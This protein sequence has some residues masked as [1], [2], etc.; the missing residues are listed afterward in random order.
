MAVPDL[1]GDGY[2]EETIR[3]EYEWKPPRCSTCLIFG[4]SLV[5]CPK[6]AF[7]RV[8]N[9]LEKGKGKSSGADD[10]G[11][12]EVKKSSGINEGTSNSPK[13]VPSAGKKNV[14]TLG[15]FSLCNSFKALNVDPVIEEVETGNKAS[16]SG[17]QEEGN[18]TIIERINVFEKHLLKEK[19]VLVDDDGKPLE[20]VDYS[21][22][23]GSEDEV[24]SINNEMARYLASKPFGVGYVE[25]DEVVK[26]IFNNGKKKGLGMRILEWMLTKE[27]KETKHYK[28]YAKE[29][30]LDVPMTHSQPIESTQGMHRTPSAPRPLTLKNNKDFEDQQAVKKVEEHLIDM[31]IEKIM[32][33][34][35]KS[36]ANKFV[37]DIMNKIEEESV[38]AAL[39]RKKGKGIV[40]IK[41]TPLTTPIRSPRTHTDSLSSYKEE[42]KELTTSKTTS[43]SSKPKTDRSKHIQ[44]AIARMSKRYGYI[45]RHMKKSFMPRKD[46]DAIGKI[47]EETLKKQERTRATFSS[48]VSNDVATKIPPQFDAFLMNYMNNHI[49]HVHPTESASSF[50]PDL[51]QQLYLKMKDDG[52]ACNADLPIWLALKYKF[53]KHATNAAPCRVDTF[54]SRDHEDHHDD[55]ARPEGE[56]TYDNEVP[57]KVVSLELLAEV[58][59][60]GIITNDLQRMQDA[61][62]N[63][64]RSLYLFYLKNGNCE[65]RKYVLSPHKV[66]AFSFLKNDLEELNTRWAQQSYIKRQLKTRDDPGEVYSKKRIVD[67]IRV[68]YDQGYVQEYMEEIMVK[69]ADG[70]Y[71]SFTESDYK[72]LHKNDI[73]DMYLMCIKSYQHKVNLTAPTLTFPGIEEQKP[74]TISSDPLVGLIYKNSKKEKKIMNIDE[75]PKFCDTALKRVLEKVKKINLDVKH[76]YAD[77]TLSKAD[78]EFMQFYEEYIQEQLRHQDHMRHWERYVNERPLKQ[79]RE[80]PE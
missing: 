73:K 27:M 17:V 65:T 79:R 22:A 59:R 10:E 13:T 66:H 4:H 31:D 53:E 16:T 54:Y 57:S 64:I 74:Y 8:V 44:G 45:F 56:S 51:Q 67:V 15:T 38:E 20:K 3:V 28:M 63:M 47:V 7:K 35:E 21:D 25:N 71:K 68:Q 61:L 34:D 77:P 43:S 12:I 72:Y 78:A 6:A 55:D 39:I 80:R 5:D 70:E 26:L 30:G 60:K 76:R 42:L 52:Q 24:E 1:E 29:F 75:I 18:T 37:D 33:G 49:L 40:E 2:I 23:Q 46:M 32:E 14:S 69:R 11:F 19:C 58:S 48:Q 41:D 36:D 50:I 62:N 9:S